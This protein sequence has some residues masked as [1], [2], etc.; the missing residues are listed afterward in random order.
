MVGFVEWHH[1][2]PTRIPFIRTFRSVGLQPLRGGNGT[3]AVPYKMDEP[4]AVQ[5]TAKQQFIVCWMMHKK[6]GGNVPLY[7]PA[8]GCFLLPVQNIHEFFAGDGFLFV[9][10]GGQLVQLLPVF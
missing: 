5:P 7:I 10:E 9:E 2:R 8:W 1:V 3:Q 4:Y 6:P